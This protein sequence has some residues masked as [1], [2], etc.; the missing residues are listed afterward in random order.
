MVLNVGL[1]DGAAI[2][3]ENVFYT[4]L[5]DESNRLKVSELI[6]G[7]PAHN[8]E[9]EHAIIQAVFKQISEQTA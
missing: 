5:L 7:L 1:L 4:L 8:S 9:Q 2:E 6:T 3:Y